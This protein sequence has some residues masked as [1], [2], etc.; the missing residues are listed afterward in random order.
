MGVAV[1]Q[2]RRVGS[3]RIGANTPAPLT[4]EESL[5]ALSGYL[6]W[7]GLR[8]PSWLACP[9][10]LLCHHVLALCLLQAPLVSPPNILLAASCLSLTLGS[11]PKLEPYKKPRL[12]MHERENTCLIRAPS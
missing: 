10:L 12:V 3:Q 7:D 9:T 8:A 4:F 11:Q 2:W 1:K 6:R 5:R